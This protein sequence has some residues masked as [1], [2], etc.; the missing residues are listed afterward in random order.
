MTTMTMQPII[1][2]E[3]HTELLPVSICPGGMK[4]RMNASREP[5][6]PTPPIIHIK[7]LPLPIRNGLV[8]SFI[9]YLKA[10]AAANISIYMIR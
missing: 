4:L 9:L 1:S 2:T 7:V 3:Y 10:I 8:A 5:Q 6:K